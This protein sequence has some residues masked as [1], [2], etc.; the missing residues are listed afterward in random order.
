MPKM[1]DRSELNVVQRRNDVNKVPVE[2]PVWEG[3]SKKNP[4]YKP[5]G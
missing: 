5:T 1:W 3:A 2:S 4:K